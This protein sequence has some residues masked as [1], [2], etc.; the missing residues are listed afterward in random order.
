MQNSSLLMQNR[1]FLIR[2]RHNYLKTL[3]VVVDRER[4][5]VTRCHPVWY[6]HSHLLLHKPHRLSAE[7]ITH[8][9]KTSSVWML[10][11]SYW[12][13]GHHSSKQTQTNT[14]TLSLFKRLT[15]R[16]PGWI[17]FAAA[18]WAALSVGISAGSSSS[19]HMP[20]GWSVVIPESTRNQSEISLSYPWQSHCV[21]GDCPVFSR[22][23]IRLRS[24]R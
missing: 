6:L 10:T 22:M 11:S 2:T 4:N 13:W 7:V 5:S 24:T 21:R 18:S 15:W 12:W 1:S 20:F 19:T 8:L 16:S 14:E 3:I 17:C 23:T 9:Y